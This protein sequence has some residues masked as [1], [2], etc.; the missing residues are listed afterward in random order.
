MITIDIDPTLFHLGPVALSWYGLA[1][2]LA[3]TVAVWLTLREARRKGIPTQP[4]ADLAVWVV[5]GGV[6]GARLLH[7]IDRWG[8]YAANPAQLLAFQ[9]GG[10]AILGAVLGGAIAAGLGARSLGLPVRRLFDAIAPGLVLGQA[11]GRFGCLVT[12]DALGP[13]TDGSWGITYLNPHAMAPQL[14]IAYQPVFLYEQLWDLAI[15][16]VLWRLRRRLTADGQVFALYLGL[17]SAGKFALTFLRT[18]TVWF[19][20]LQEAQ[21]VALVGVAIAVAWAVRARPTIAASRTLSE[22]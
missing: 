17:Y 4:V 15:F 20:G 22:S 1:V 12:G 9:N 16:A 7:V 3:V 5:V 11:I 2:V 8:D 6:V 19:W 18:E 21:L 13:P 14:G 10:L